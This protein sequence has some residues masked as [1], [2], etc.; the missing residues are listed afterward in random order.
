M[1]AA[2]TSYLKF[3][4][5]VFLMGVEHERAVNA[6]PL[7]SGVLANIMGRAVK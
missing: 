2:E 1:F 7:L 4:S 5:L 6:A 3:N